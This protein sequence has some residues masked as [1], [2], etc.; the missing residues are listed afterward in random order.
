M[1]GRTGC[2]GI[3]RVWVA[4]AVGPGWWVYGLG[5]WRSGVGLAGQAGWWGRVGGQ[6]VEGC[7]G[8]VPGG[9][10]FEQVVHGAGEGPFGGGFGF[11]AHGEL[12]EAHVVLDLAVRGLGDVAALA[13]G[14]DAV[15][16]G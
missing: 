15:F 7:G 16:G 5:W 3:G 4:G 1:S 8:E 11:A 13:V 6:V 2:S 14:G 10:G 9:D 12:A